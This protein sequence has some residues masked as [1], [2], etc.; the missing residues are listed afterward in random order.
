MFN[1]L[2]ISEPVNIFNYNVKKPPEVPGFINKCNIMRDNLFK[3][4]VLNHFKNNPDTVIVNMIKSKNEYCKK[5]NRRKTINVYFDKKLRFCLNP[6]NRLICDLCVSEEIKEE[7]K[8]KKLLFYGKDIFLK[9][10]ESQVIDIFNFIA[11]EFKGAYLCFNTVPKKLT[12][13]PYNDFTKYKW[14]NSNIRFLESKAKGLKALNAY[15]YFSYDKEN[16]GW[17]YLLSSNQNFMNGLK[18]VMMKAV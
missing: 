16:W 15:Y 5:I 9:Y 11:S 18:V 17:Y 1:N 13:Y 12:E 10:T 4:V 14:S 7:T 3:K 8:G 6:E 2:K